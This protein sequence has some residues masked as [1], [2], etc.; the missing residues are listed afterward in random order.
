[1]NKALDNGLVALVLIASVA[2]AFVALGPKTP[3]KRLWTGLARLAARAPPRLHLDGIARRLERAAA[4][5]TGGCGGCEQCEPEPVSG[6]KS[7]SG[8]HRVANGR[9]SEVR[10]PLKDIGRR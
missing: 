9:G 6:A 3:L 1:M 4:T 8:Q 5:R 2:Y 10:V 7:S